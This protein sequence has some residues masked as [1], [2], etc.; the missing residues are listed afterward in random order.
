MPVQLA[1]HKNDK[2][3]LARAIQLWTKS[4]YSHCELVIDGKCYSSS[5]M[6]KGVRCKPVGDGKDE[7][8]L[9][10]DKWDII[11]IPWADAQ[12]IKDYFTKTDG[13]SYGWWSLIT[14]Q[15]FNMNRPAHESEF[16]SEWCAS[17]LGLEN[18]SSYSPETLSDM[19][20]YLNS[21]HR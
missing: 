14:S 13:Y 17:A 18:T 7:I 11:D 8:S 3:I 6:D 15:L 16:C 1:L 9:S 12:F 2:R 21:I 5:V 10:P 4:I 19:V 20:R